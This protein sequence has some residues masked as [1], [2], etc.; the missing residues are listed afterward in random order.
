MMY[1]DPFELDGFRR[2]YIRALSINLWVSIHVTD[3]KKW[4]NLTKM[5][6]ETRNDG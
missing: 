5:V 1:I 2:F 6:M 4:S 3:R